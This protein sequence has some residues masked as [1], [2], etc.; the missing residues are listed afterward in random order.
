MSATMNAS[1]C[2]CSS[3]TTALPSHRTAVNDCKYLVLERANA[4]DCVSN[5]RGTVERYRSL[6][7]LPVAKLIQF[8]YRSSQHKTT[9]THGMISPRGARWYGPQ[10]P[11][12]DCEKNNVPVYELLGSHSIASNHR[13]QICSGVSLH[14]TAPVMARIQ[15][16]VLRTM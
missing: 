14:Y 1:S 2:C 16:S 12:S 5:E 7:S 4:P 6:R 13:D 15:L 11:Q 9:V 10:G 3:A 8:L